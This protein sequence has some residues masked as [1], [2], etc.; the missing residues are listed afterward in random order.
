M[1]DFFRK[2]GFLLT[3]VNVWLV[4]AAAAVSRL[5]PEVA[6][7]LPTQADTIESIAV[8]VVA[9]LTAAA[10]IVRRSLPIAKEADPAMKY[11]P[12]SREDQFGVDTGDI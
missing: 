1:I 8:V 7:V 3:Q 11:V 4:G 10:A 6:E 12:T 9:W 5:A 2:I